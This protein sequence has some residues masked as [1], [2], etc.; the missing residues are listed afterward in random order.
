[1]LLV[2]GRIASMRPFQHVLTS[3]IAEKLRKYILK[4]TLTK[5]HAH[6]F[7]IPQH[8]K[9]TISVTLWLIVYIY[10]IALSSNLI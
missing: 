10:M 3:Y 2:H 7:A 1:M 5:Y 4:L 6:F 9:L 8:G